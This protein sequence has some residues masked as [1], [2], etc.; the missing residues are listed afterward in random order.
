MLEYINRR[1]ST[2]SFKAQLDVDAAASATPSGAVE[3]AP[4]LNQPAAAL[5][6][7]SGEATLAR[8]VR[9]LLPTP[10]LA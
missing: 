3:P 1:N 6:T 4:P 5:L 8:A 10:L 2:S 9:V 7:K